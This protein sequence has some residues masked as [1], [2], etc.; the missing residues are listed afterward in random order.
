MVQVAS[1]SNSAD[2]YNRDD[3]RCFRREWNV[4]VDRYSEAT[5]RNGQLEFAL[6][7]FQAT[8]SIMEAE[9]NMVWAQLAESDARV[10]GKIFNI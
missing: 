1:S 5:R 4:V 3:V 9:A 2:S 8:L 10:A 6:N 7:A